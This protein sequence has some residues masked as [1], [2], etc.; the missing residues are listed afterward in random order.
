MRKLVY[1]FFLSLIIFLSTSAIEN[2]KLIKILIPDDNAFKKLISIGVDL[3]GASGKV[4]DWYQLTVSD[5]EMKL[6]LNEGFQINVEIEDLTQFYSSRLSKQAYDALGFGYGSMGG[7]YTFDEASRQLDTMRL[8]YPNLITAKFS[9]GNSLQGRPIWAVKISKNADLPST[10]PEVFYNALTHAREPAGMMSLIYFMWHLLQNYGTDS[11][12]T[13][14]VD[15]RQMYIVPVVNP[16]GYEANRRFAPNGGGMRRKNMRNAITDNDV[17]GVDLNRNFGY[18]WG[19]DN[20]GSSPTPTAATYRGTSAFSEP[21]TQVLRDFCISRSAY[22]G[23]KLVLNYHTYSNLLI[24]PWGYIPSAET[25]DSLLY[26]EYAKDMTQFNEYVYGTPSQLLYPVNGGSD[27]WMYGEQ[28]MKNKILSMTP[29]VGTSTD[30]FWPPT[31][32]ILPLAQENLFP[33]LYLAHVAGSYPRVQ[34]IAIFDSSGDGYTERGE[35]FYIKFTMRNKGLEAAQNVSLQLSSSNPYIQVPSS[36]IIFGVMNSLSNKIDSIQCSIAALAQNGTSAQIFAAITEQSGRILYDTIPVL[37]G[38]KIVKLVFSDS[39]SNGTGNWN[40]GTSWGLSSDNHTPP[41]SF[42]DSP[43]GLYDNSADNSMTLNTSLILSGGTE[44]KL[45]FWTK[46]AVETK[47]DFATVEAS[48][49]GGS[50]WSTL[51]GKYT[52]PGSGSGVQTSGSYGFDGTQ[53]TWVEEEMDVTRF[54]SNQFKFRFRLRSD[55]YITADGF[56]VDDIRLIVY[57]PDTT[58]YR[59]MNISLGA[60]D[61][62]KLG[63]GKS[64]DTT[65]IIGNLPSSN[66]N[67]SG[68]STLVLSTGYNLENGGSFEIP[69]GGS[70]EFHV[71]FN[72]LSE[73]ALNDTLLITHNGTSLQ[74]PV[75]IVLYGI[76][77]HPPQFLTKLIIKNTIHTDSLFF[78]EAYGATDGV[79]TLY[80]E[81][82]LEPLPPL[83]YFDVRW[84]ISGTN[85]TLLD[86]RDTLGASNPINIFECIFQVGTGGYP[87][88]ISWNSDSL[89]KGAFILKDAL[90]AGNL[91][92]INMKN[93]DS[94]I[95]SDTS[96]NALLIEHQNLPSIKL[97]VNALWNLVSLPSEVENPRKNVLFPTVSSQAFTY[98]G[99]YFSRDTLK[100]GEGYWLKFNSP[101]EIEITG[102]EVMTDTID[103][104]EGWNLI[105]SIS[106]PVG[107][108]GIITEPEN[109]ISSVF[110]GYD[111]GYK[112]VQL[113]MPGQAYWVKVKQNG[114]LILS[115]NN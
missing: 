5:S 15:N 70:Q 103:V 95:V 50:T 115:M 92:H 33:N 35:K 18:M 101:E 29:E 17:Q 73:G 85:G 99:N 60:I 11:E 19:Y 61:F 104:F 32:R 20:S 74:S 113:I 69:V 1:T 105:G 36:P 25:P 58:K 84:N 45:K 81:E 91:V 110:Y 12:A 38:K 26:R 40:L 30:G 64:K 90:T 88:T 108:N 42:T 46:W 75:K 57:T 56:Y 59:D 89:P 93:T 55:S 82:E 52:K 47:W 48:S 10:R 86:M 14:L 37:I 114:K 62:G 9:I 3:E 34:Q 24:Y 80:G 66:D 111:S 106:Q 39:A 21:E 23:I 96:I 83:D 94:V 98:S 112:A 22:G 87:I 53:S 97:S 67:L 44:V 109:I 79:D 51:K 68:L 4:G 27:D 31:S 2:Y 65:I 72:P 100:R 13:Y 41:Y 54:I 78:G 63:I 7:Y 107:V 76:A 43:A 102:Y 71:S 8:L 16:D 6:L 49:N 28:T 77:Y